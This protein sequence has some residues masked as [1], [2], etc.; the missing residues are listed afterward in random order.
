[1]L[2]G[3][4]ETEKTD[5][6]D[7]ELP[8]ID[9]NGKYILLK[10]QEVNTISTVIFRPPYPW[11]PWAEESDFV[12][13][14]PDMDADPFATICDRSLYPSLEHV[15]SLLP[16]HLHRSTIEAQRSACRLDRSFWK[17]DGW[18]LKNLC[19][20]WVEAKGHVSSDPL[21]NLR[22]L[23]PVLGVHAFAMQLVRSFF[24]EVTTHELLL[25]TILKLG[26][27]QVLYHRKAR[28]EWMDL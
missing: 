15:F 27:L 2:S 4:Q 8:T 12:L 18:A 26:G 25:L 1:M 9:S 23:V 10:S 7:N 13:P 16:Q 21:L 22:R 5:G 17:R 3:E 11:G 24:G 28:I 20:N 14:H 6:A 19:L